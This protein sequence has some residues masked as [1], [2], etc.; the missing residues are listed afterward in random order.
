MAQAT[1]SKRWL[2]YGANGYTGELIARE[3]VRLGLR[4][5]L[6][7]RSA[8]KIKALAAELGCPS[9]VFR[10]DDHTATLSSLEGVAAV[11][12]CAGPFSSTAAPLMQA[13]MAS[14]AHY[15]DITGE[16]DVFEHA[17]S[18]D[19]QAQRA[20]CVVCPGVG[21]DVVPTDC[22]AA[23]LKAALPDATHLA[24]G[25]DGLGGFSRGSARTMVESLHTGTRVRRE[26]R[27][28]SLP[29]GEPTRRIDFGKGERLGVALSWGDVST[30]YYTTGIPNIEV[31]RA[32]SERQLERMRSMNRWR[33]LARSKVVQYFLK[34]SMSPTTAGPSASER[35]NN[36]MFVWG[37][38]VNAKGVRKTARVTTANGYQATVYAALGIVHD[39]LETTPAPGFKTPSMLVGADYVSHL[40]GS[41]TLRIE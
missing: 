37:E 22:V 35:A 19:G 13:C 38:V 36:S 33:G 1:D 27:I 7:G 29:L 12:N 15:F 41:T 34:R 16:I 23:A 6:A 17:H 24:L 40:P 2:L 26:G 32:M 31:Y 25:F 9:A 30:A 4:P 5:T 3:A 18:L 11:L 28:V 14:H 8:E 21:F 39:M 20:G 10:L